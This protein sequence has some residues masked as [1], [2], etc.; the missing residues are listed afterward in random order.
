M[1]L[2][3]HREFALKFNS[4]KFDEIY[5]RLDDDNIEKLDAR[6]DKYFLWSRSTKSENNND[7][8]SKSSNQNNT[9]NKL[10]M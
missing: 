5:Y 8:D 4:E 6:W 3:G 9:G 1:V 10:T 2:L 7:V